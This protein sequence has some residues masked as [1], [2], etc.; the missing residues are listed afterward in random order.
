MH[1]LSLAGGSLD[2][3]FSVHVLER[4]LV[5]L[6]VHVVLRLSLLLLL[7]DVVERE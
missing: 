5:P 6:R 3:R 2:T 7:L 4:L 1:G